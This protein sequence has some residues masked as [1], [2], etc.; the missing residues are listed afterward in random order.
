ML[1][2][3]TLNGA[4]YALYT[5]RLTASSY[6]KY[7]KMQISIIPPLE[8]RQVLQGHTKKSLIKEFP[9][10]KMEKDYLLFLSLKKYSRYQIVTA[11]KKVRPDVKRKH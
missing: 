11:T 4:L 2:N 3:F 7:G 6:G 8:T 1:K 5:A 10:K 9:S